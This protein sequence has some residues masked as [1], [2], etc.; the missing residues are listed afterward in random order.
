VALG[1]DEGSSVLIDPADTISTDVGGSRV[2]KFSSGYPTATASGLLVPLTVSHHEPTLRCS[3]STPHLST[4]RRPKR[5]RGILS[6][7]SDADTSLVS[8][9]HA[10]SSLPDSESSKSCYMIIAAAASS[11]RSRRAS[12][13]PLAILSGAPLMEHSG[14]YPSDCTIAETMP[15][16][17]SSPAPLQALSERCAPRA[18]A[19]RFAVHSM[20][21]VVLMSGRA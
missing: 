1:R 13:T 2:C 19:Y 20:L 8:S 18:R 15:S 6:A 11:H 16:S 3:C 17:H 12:T 7:S 10:S 5:F 21:P 9:M 14:S 4:L